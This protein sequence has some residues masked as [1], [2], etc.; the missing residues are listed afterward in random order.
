MTQIQTGAIESAPDYRDHIMTASMAP[1]LAPIVLPASFQSVLGPVLMQ[2]HIPACVSHDIVDAIKL[3][4]FRE[5][6]EWVDFSPRFLDI[7]SAEEWIPLEGGRV[8]RTVLKVASKMGVCTT[9]TLPNDTT[10]S[11]AEYRNPS[12]ITAEARA[13]ALKYRIPGYIRIPVDFI[14]TRKAI[15]QFGMVTTC[16]KVGAELYTPSWA[17]QDINPLRTPNPVTSGHEM[18]QK[19]WVNDTLNT[20]R[21]EWSE[22]W[23]K[24]GEADFN[25]E[26]WK[27]F[28]AEQW[29]IAQVP[30]NVAAFMANLPYKR[31]FSYLW[32]TNL[33]RGDNNE[34]VKFFQIAMMILGFLDP[35][36]VNPADLG[37]FGPKTVDANA[38]YQTS[39][40]ISPS[41]E[42]VGPKTR[43]ALNKEF[44]L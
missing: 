8:P 15:L 24:N 10:L 41:G 26:E 16:Y 29:A 43:D 14:Q 17:E 38:R 42:N 35:L 1:T 25:Y 3:W 18:G 30:Q 31:D 32:D 13:E 37:N 11:I 44:T 20:L 4:W 12:A 36:K 28:I 27:P 19:G 5:H 33:K 39:K 7:L 22:Q 9:K 21:N 34:D 23:C 6:G 2:R 40:G